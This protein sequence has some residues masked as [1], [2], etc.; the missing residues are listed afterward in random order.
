M[1]VVHNYFATEYLSRIVIVLKSNSGKF[2]PPEPRVW[3]VWVLE[4]TKSVK[5]L[6]ERTGTIF[7]SLCAQNPS[8]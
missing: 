2:E 8:A 1:A 5:E 4:A 6:G 3:R 7:S